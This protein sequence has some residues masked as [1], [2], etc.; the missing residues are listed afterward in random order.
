MIKDDQGPEHYP[1]IQTT[2]IKGVLLEKMPI[3]DYKHGCLVEIVNKNWADMFKDSIEHLY[4]IC[5][6]NENLRNEW[7]VHYK[8]ED[9]YVLIDG[10]LLVALFDDRSDSET[11]CK[12]EIL[13]LSNIKS[14]NNCCLKI[15]FGIWHSLHQTSELMILMNVKANGYNRLDPDKY[16]ISMPNDKIDFCWE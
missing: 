12:F 8:T 15:P 9:R 1:V 2:T 16:R 10:E 7:Y 3:V 14:G 11:Y 4:V 13:K 6:T 5:N